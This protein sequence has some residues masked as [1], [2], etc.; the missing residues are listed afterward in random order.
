MIDVE[1]L[2]PFQVENVSMG[3]H[4]LRIIEKGEK[5]STIRSKKYEY[6]IGQV[7]RMEWK[8]EEKVTYAIIMDKNDIVVPHDLNE[9]LLMREGNYPN[10]KE[11]YAELK[12]LGF[13][14]EN[15]PR[16]FWQYDIE[17]IETVDLEED[18]WKDKE[19]GYQKDDDQE[20]LNPS[21]KN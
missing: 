18:Y 21:V 20:T 19:V 10:I 6:Q 2:R 13:K 3:D 12:R 7:M 14:T 11:F 17:F 15:F 8:E 9:H 16:E 5:T 4:H 1:D